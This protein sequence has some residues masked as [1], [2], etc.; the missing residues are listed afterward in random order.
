[1]KTV[2]ETKACIIPVL[3][4]SD[5]ARAIDWL[6]EAFGFQKHFVAPGANGSIDHAQLTLGNSMIMLSSAHDNEFAKLQTT[7]QNCGDITTQSTY[8]IVENVDAHHNRAVAAG[9]QIVMQLRDEPYGGRHYSCKDLEGH[10]WNFGNYNP[11]QEL[12]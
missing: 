4:Y 11:W 10:L 1:M 2:I 6:C 5:A 3:R 12:K 7:P 9:A 8:I